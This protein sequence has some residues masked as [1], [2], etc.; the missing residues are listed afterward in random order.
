MALFAV[1]TGCRDREICG[2]RWEWEVKV[3]E[4]ETIVFIIPGAHVKNGRDRLVVLNRIAL[5]I[6]ESRRGK[7]PTHVFAIFRGGRYKGCS[8]PPGRRPGNGQTCPGS[9]STTSST[10]S[11]GVCVLQVS[12][13]R[14]ARTLLGHRSG[15]ITTHYS[16]AELGRLIEAAGNGCRPERK[17]GR[18]WLFSGVKLGNRI[19]AK[20]PHG[21][22]RENLETSQV[23]ENA[24]LGEPGFEPGPTESES[25]VLPLNYSPMRGRHWHTPRD[26]PVTPAHLGHQPANVKAAKSA[27]HRHCL[28]TNAAVTGSAARPP[29]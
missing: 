29:P 20:L 19:H 27:R 7:H 26:P 24:W 5:S 22:R 9:A 8:T 15:R 6:V 17:E 14:I 10:P 16:A 28:G 11:A 1:N 21:S 25:A 23:I 2:L 3:P 13:S 4:L 18:N 12:L